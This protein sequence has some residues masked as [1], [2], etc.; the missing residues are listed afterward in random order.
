MGGGAGVLATRDFLPVFGGGVSSSPVRLF[1]FE[2]GSGRGGMK[3]VGDDVPVFV[4]VPVPVAPPRRPL[5]PPLRSLLCTDERVSVKL[6]RSF[7]GVVLAAARPRLP[8]PFGVRASRS[9]VGESQNL[10][11]QATGEKQG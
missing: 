7:P 4:P 9:L 1:R 5:P 6:L 3:G 10:E 11:Q 2:L 8:R